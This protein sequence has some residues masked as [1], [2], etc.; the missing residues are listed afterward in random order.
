MKNKLRSFFYAQRETLM[1]LICGICTVCVNTFAFLLLSVFLD[2]I[3][4]N[5]AAFFVS[6]FFAYITN[7]LFVFRKSISWKTFS[8][9]FGLR[10]GTILLDNGGLY[11]FLLLFEDK[12]ASKLIVNVMLIVLNYLFSKLIIYRSKEK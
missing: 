6:T 4:S 11:L 12:V 7:T 9:F 5:T 2:E 10:I 8:M 3:L 1:Y